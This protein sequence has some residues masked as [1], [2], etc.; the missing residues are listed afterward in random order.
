MSG[1]R[2]DVAAWLAETWDPE[3]PLLEWRELLAASGWG[4]PTKEPSV[5]TEVP[6]REVRRN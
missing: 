2:D 3:R 6:F 4:C 5:D 1:T